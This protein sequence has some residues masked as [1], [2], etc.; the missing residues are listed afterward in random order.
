MSTLFW[1]EFGILFLAALIGAAAVVPYGLRLAQGKPLKFSIQ[2]VFL[3]SLVQNAILFGI[4]IGLGLLAAHAIGLGAPYL[5]SL[6]A[7]A[8]IPGS[9]GPVIALVLGSVAGASLLI[10][11][12]FFEPYWPQA[13]REVALKTSVLENLLASLYGGVNEELLLRLFG[14]SALAWLLSLVT[15]LS[16]PILWVVNVV[17][18]ILFGAGHLPALKQMLGSIPRLMMIRTMFLNAP[19]GLLCG[20]LFWTYGIEAAIVAHFSTDIVYHVFGTFVLRRI[21]SRARA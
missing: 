9:A 21:G 17:M 3:L 10:A 20:W 16:T 13:L 14:F 19:I 5:E 15:P 4:A 6:L 8:N 11:D 18:T 1:P 7:G 12:L 2:V